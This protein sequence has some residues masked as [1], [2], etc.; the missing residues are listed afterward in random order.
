MLERLLPRFD[1]PASLR[2]PGTL[3]AGTPALAIRWLGTAGHRLAWG[4]R[5]VLIDPFVS[6]PRLSRLFRPLASDAREL[7]RWAPEADAIVCGHAH[8][9]HLLDAPAIARRTGAIVLGSPSTARVALGH[10]VERARVR[11]TRPGGL[12]EAVG[13]FEVELVPSVHAK[14]LLGKKVVFPG[15]IRRTRRRL[16]RVHEYKDGGALGVF[17]RAGGVTV[18]HNGSAD[19]VDVALEGKRAD[20]LLCGIAGWRYAEGY[21]ARLV[22][23]LQPKL[24][25]PTHYDVFFGPLDEG[26]RLIPGV[27]LERFLEECARVAPGVPVVAPTPWEELLVSPDGRE[28]GIVPARGDG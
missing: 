2:P 1:A 13:D 28:F 4:G 23:L 19:L 20:V 10:G 7:D 15:F 3:R 25:V 9:D 21:V 17:V 6:R 18:Y 27:G 8:F 11:V 24:I 22:R 14:V 16:L 12:R 26:V 5:R